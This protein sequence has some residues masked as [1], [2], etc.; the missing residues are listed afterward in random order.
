MRVRPSGLPGTQKTKRNF[1]KDHR[2]SM[3]VSSL[4]QPGPSH[5]LV[6]LM[7]TKDARPHSSGGTGRGWASLHAA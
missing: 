4:D 2:V 6:L 3:F 1:P 7:E 5:V